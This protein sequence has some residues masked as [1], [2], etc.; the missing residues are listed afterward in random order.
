MNGKESFFLPFQ[1][2]VNFSASSQFVI[3]LQMNHGDEILGP[4]GQANPPQLRGL[5]CG[6]QPDIFASDESDPHVFLTTAQSIEAGPRKQDPPEIERKTFATEHNY[7]PQRERKLMLGKAP[8]P[9]PDKPEDLPHYVKLIR[10]LKEDKELTDRLS[11]L[12]ELYDQSKQTKVA[13]LAQKGEDEYFKPLQRRIKNQMVGRSYQHFLKTKASAQEEWEQNPL[14][15]SDALTKVPHLV[16]STRGLHD[17]TNRY[18]EHRDMER[19]FEKR[20]AAMSGQPIVEEEKPQRKT[21]DYGYL[22][23]QAETRF[24]DGDARPRGKKFFNRSLHSVSAP[25]FGDL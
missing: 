19:Q 15:S 22:E 1:F 17:P 24:F 13:A 12:V 23:A 10:S 18:A 3:F 7:S 5:L 16:V 20:I 21:M 25:T 9:P 6:R 2:C 11:D 14:R 4:G 8:S